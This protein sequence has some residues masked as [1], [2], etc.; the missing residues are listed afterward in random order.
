MG[1]DTERQ[2]RILIIQAA[3]MRLNPQKALSDSFKFK[4]TL[5]ATALTNSPLS[6]K[7]FLP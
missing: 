7:N 6:V 1:I 3:W 4:S 5:N 2:K